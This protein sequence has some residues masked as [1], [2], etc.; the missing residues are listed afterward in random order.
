MTNYNRAIKLRIKLEASN[1]K[2]TQF[3]Y[4]IEAKTGYSN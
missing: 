2:K 1:G 4:K 3:F